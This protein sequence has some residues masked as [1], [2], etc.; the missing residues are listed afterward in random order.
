MLVWCTLTRI[1]QVIERTL[2]NLPSSTILN[3]G[4]MR[5]RVNGT[6]LLM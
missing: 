6:M 5:L 3:E 1:N 2:L 4:A